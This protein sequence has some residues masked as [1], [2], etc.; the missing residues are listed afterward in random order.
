M[1]DLAKRLESDFSVRILAMI[2]SLRHFLGWLVIA[3]RSRE[4]LVLESLAVPTENV[5]RVRMR[6]KSATYK[7]RKMK[8]SLVR[9]L[10]CDNVTLRRNRLDGIFADHRIIPPLLL[11]RRFF[12][13]P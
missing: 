13:S 5:I 7:K 9:R 6:L 12:D 1:N 8:A 10:E 4:D 11:H 2:V 3:F